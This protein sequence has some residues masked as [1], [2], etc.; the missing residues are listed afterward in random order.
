VA[1]QKQITANRRNAAR[2]TGPRTLDGKQ[3]S[4][5]N[6]LRHGLSYLGGNP[7]DVSIEEVSQGLHQIRIKRTEMLATID[8]M[9]MAKSDPEAIDRRIKQLSALTRYDGRMYSMRRRQ[10]SSG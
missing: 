5:M 10:N 3:R 2:S 8:A 6:A 1:T 9:I 7:D 4:R